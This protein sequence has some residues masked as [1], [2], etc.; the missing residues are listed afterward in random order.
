MFNSATIAC[1]PGHPILKQYIEFLIKNENNFPD[2]PNW[3]V[4]TRT[5]PTIFSIFFNHFLDDIFILDPE[6]I[7]PWGEVTK[8]TVLNHEYACS[9]MHPA[10]RWM[11]PYYLHFRNNFVFI[12]LLIIILTY[13]RKLL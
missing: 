1:E 12:L 8:R 3:D 10:V 11:A 9:W 4:E 5:G 2:D 7:E 13:L 6:I